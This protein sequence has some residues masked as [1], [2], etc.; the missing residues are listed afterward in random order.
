MGEAGSC[1]A[2]RHRGF[3]S[4]LPLTAPTAAITPQAHGRLTSR[5]TS[6]HRPPQTSECPKFSRDLWDTT[7]GNTAR[8]VPPTHVSRE[9]VSPRPSREAAVGGGRELRPAPE[10]RWLQRHHKAPPLSKA[11]RGLCRYRR[12]FR[13]ADGRLQI[14]STP[15]RRLLKSRSEH[16]AG[17]A[18]ALRPPVGAA[19]ATAGLRRAAAA[20]GAAR[21]GVPAMSGSRAA[22]PG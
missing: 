19:A 17:A 12:A 7:C 20:G 15:W 22:P 3:P 16:G 18:I 2:G 8:W 10:D 5:E 21:R 9:F 14:A 1:P 6:S 4:P 13:A 11:P